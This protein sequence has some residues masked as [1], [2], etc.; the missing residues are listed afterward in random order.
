ME[1]FL[2]GEMSKIY[3]TD[4]LQK[5]SLLEKNLG[6]K[7]NYQILEPFTLNS[8]DI[9]GI[10]SAGKKIANFIGLTD[11]TFIIATTKQ[12]KNVG[13][14]IE[15]NNE[16]NVF[17]ELSPDTL[18]FPESILASLSHEITHKYLHIH[19]L[20]FD[21]TY[22]NEVLTDIAAVF[23]GIGKLILNGCECKR[24]Y[25]EYASGGTKVIT[26]TIKTGYLSREQIAFVYL[27]TCS[28]RKI[29]SDTYESNLNKD[30]INVLRCCRNQYNFYFNSRFHNPETNN[31]SI[32]CLS[33]AV[34][35]NQFI[36]SDIDINLLY[37]QN[38]LSKTM[39]SFLQENHQKLNKLFIKSTQ[40]TDQKQEDP[41]LRYIYSLQTEEYIR[42]AINEINSFSKK[43]ICY[44]KIILKFVNSIM[45]SNIF[46]L[47]SLKLNAEMFNIIVCR[48]CEAKLRLPGNKTSLLAK[49]PTCQYQFIASTSL[50]FNEN[51]KKQK[52]FI[53]KIKKIF[54][55]TK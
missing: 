21:N 23:L 34:R 55:R 18:K 29:S 7:T 42:D 3:I 51:F 10:Q 14:H 35:K 38:V 48:N 49:C 47:S 40:L 32:E 6:A 39:N 4:Y 22:E 20:K 30:A 28:M 15:L 19:N 33:S 8:Q 36:L 24:T 26:E 17:I 37:L 53:K 54:N 46:L 43:A 12:K 11:L 1:I 41:C 2:G 5:L 16:K 9:I 31:K 45:N 52:S 50:R 27:L 13:G 25:E 44:K